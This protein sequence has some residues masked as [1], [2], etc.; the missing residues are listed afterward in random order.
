MLTFLNRSLFVI[1]LVTLCVTFFARKSIRSVS[2]ITPG[3]LRQPLQERTSGRPVEFKKGEY[4]YTITPLYNY[5]ITALVTHNINYKK[6]SVYQYSAVVPADLCLIWGGNLARK[7]HRESSVRFT[8]DVRFGLVM[9]GPKVDFDTGEFSNNHLVTNDPEIEKKINSISPGDQVRIKGKLV[10]MTATAIG[11]VKWPDRPKYEWR[12]STVRTDDRGGACE[13]IHV[14]D[15]EVLKKGN[16]L[17]HL[18]FRISL[19]GLAILIA[20]NLFRF[21]FVQEKV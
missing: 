16:E 6:F 17:S 3:A 13:I 15:I 5:D 7:V 11:P 18:L 9:W 8:Q 21:F 19:Y 14:E 2:E 1:L 20:I 12:T 10:N 4:H